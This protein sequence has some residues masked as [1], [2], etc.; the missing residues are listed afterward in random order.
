MLGIFLHVEGDGGSFTGSAASHFCQFLREKCFKEEDIPLSIL[1]N[2]DA[3]K[4]ATYR[5]MRLVDAGES[6]A[7]REGQGRSRKLIKAKEKKVTY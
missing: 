5:V 4:N 1:R 7:Q 2:W 6:V 3:K